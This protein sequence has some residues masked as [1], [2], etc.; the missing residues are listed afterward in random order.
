MVFKLTMAQKPTATVTKTATETEIKKGEELRVYNNS[1]GNGNSKR[2]TV[3]WMR[4][5][6]GVLFE[7]FCGML[8]REVG[9]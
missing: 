1:N 5:D 4:G 2:L 8:R 9:G 7:S 6:D 3:R